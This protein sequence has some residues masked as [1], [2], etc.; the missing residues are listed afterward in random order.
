MLPDLFKPILLEVLTRITEGDGKEGDIEFLE[1]LGYTIKDASQCGLG[2]TL[3]NPV[4]STIKNFRDEYEAHIKDK[5]CPAHVCKALIDFH[6]D[7]D[8]CTGC[9]V[10]A[11]KCPAKA[12]TGN[13]KETHIIN[14][15]ECIKCGIC[16]TVCKFD[17]VKVG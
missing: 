8:K 11:I 4:L 14:Q 17:A 6:I 15:D 9:T 7:P 5:K 16:F 10:C 3:P 13:R 1:E 2:Q 12:I